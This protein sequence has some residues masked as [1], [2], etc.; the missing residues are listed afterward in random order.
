MGW[1]T[2][3]STSRRASPTR[4]RPVWEV[5]DPALSIVRLHGRNHGTWNKKGLTSSA[6]RFNYD[7]DEGELTEVAQNVGTLSRKAEIVHVL[8]N[9]NYQDQGQRAARTLNGILQSKK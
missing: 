2:S 5:T 6:Q 1:S 7:Y 9:T 3:L 4:Y 8:F